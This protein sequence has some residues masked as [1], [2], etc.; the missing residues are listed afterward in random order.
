VKAGPAR[1]NLKSKD[2]FVMLQHW[3]LTS[4]AWRA[5]PSL[6]KAIYIEEFELSYTGAN[7]GDILLS[8]REIAK[9][10]NCVQRTAAKMLRLLYE[11]GFIRPHVKGAFHVKTR[12]AT[13]WILTRYE[14]H[15]QKPTMDFMRWQPTAPSAVPRAAGSRRQAADSGSSKFK[16][17]MLSEQQMAPK[18]L[19]LLLLEHQIRAFLR[20]RRML[21]EQ[22]I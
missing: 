4:R 16:Q 20:L 1:K 21:S 11:H 2:K 18:G 3:L 15:G 17:R 9:A 7:N 10:N 14:F 6:A 12:V 5:L 8:E 22:H 13:T 19:N